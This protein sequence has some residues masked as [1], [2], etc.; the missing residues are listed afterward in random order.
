[1]NG[2]IAL[3]RVSI[4]AMYSV[5]DTTCLRGIGSVLK[6]QEKTIEDPHN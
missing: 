4:H 3:V 2:G 5:A 6:F 1:M